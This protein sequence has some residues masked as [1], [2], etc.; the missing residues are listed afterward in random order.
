MNI[1]T[2]SP[3]ILAVNKAIE[4]LFKQHKFVTVDNICFLTGYSSNEIYTALSLDSSLYN[5][6]YVRD[7]RK[8]LE[9]SLYKYVRESLETDCVRKYIEE[10]WYWKLLYAYKFFKNRTDK[11]RIIAFL[12]KYDLTLAFVEHF[13][14]EHEISAPEF[15]LF[16]SSVVN[17]LN[18]IEKK[19]H[20]VQNDISSIAKELSIETIKDEDTGTINKIWISKRFLKQETLK[21]LGIKCIEVEILRTPKEVLSNNIANYSKDNLVNIGDDGII[22]VGSYVRGG[23]ILVA[24][25]IKL[26]KP[27]FDQYYENSS[28]CLSA[29]LEG[30]VVD[31]I[32]KSKNKGDILKGRTEQLISIFI[33]LQET[34]T[35]GDVFVD[36][37]GIKGVVCGVVDRE[38]IDI[39]TNF[40]FD[41]K[42][43]KRISTTTCPNLFYARGTGDYSIFNDKPIGTG[44]KSPVYLSGLDVKKF[45]KTGYFSVLQNLYTCI[46]PL[47]REKLKQPNQINTTH[48]KQIG[49][50]SGYNVRQFLML[51]RALGVN[52]YLSSKKIVEDNYEY[53]INAEDLSIS[54]SPLTDENILNISMGEVTEEYDFNTYTGEPLKNG[55]FDPF[56]FGKYAISTRERMGHIELPIKY[57]N[58]LF[59]QIE[60]SKILVYPSRYRNFQPKSEGGYAVAN[61]SHSAYYAVIKSV[62]AIKRSSISGKNIYYEPLKNRIKGLFVGDMFNPLS[63]NADGYHGLFAD[64]FDRLDDFF[65]NMPIDYAASLR[66]TVSNKLKQGECLLPWIVVREI[67]GNKIKQWIINGALFETLEEENDLSESLRKAIYTHPNL[68]CEYLKKREAEKYL[69]KNSEKQELIDFVNTCLLNERIFVFSR[70]D[71]GEIIELKLQATNEYKSAIILNAEDYRNLNTEV[72][73]AVKVVYSPL[74]YIKSTIDI[75]RIHNFCDLIDMF[76]KEK[77]STAEKIAHI[78]QWIS[79]LQE[80]PTVNSLAFCLLTGRR[81]NEI[82][83]KE[84]TSPFV[85]FDSD[86]EQRQKDSIELLLKKLMQR[87]IEDDDEYDDSV[88]LTFLDDN[89]IVED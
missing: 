4:D 74:G 34:V 81:A 82:E 24:K 20:L 61:L 70:G 14:K 89:D 88:D 30:V 60:L 25:Q 55:I 17:Y 18:K 68:C 7:V 26:K 86:K 3:I 15:Y 23:D 5:K 66:A 83:R 1:F 9:S 87:P 54:L 45:S 16:R 73:K 59:P 52:I 22:K 36:K 42:E 72:E 84:L 65:T 46:E 51:L 2:S 75:K 31:V 27:H 50:Y 38:D 10:Q 78:K 71:S 8:Y 79:L 6:K 33:E 80:K 67:F 21:S 76:C 11:E 19:K 40:S 37:N 44:F 69:K 13:I 56:I 12:E 35:A 48:I 39:I 29:M 53:G 41:G 77:I 28:V 43:I 64:I 49:I 32:V 85:I 57:Q 63:T 47:I 62:K 58:F